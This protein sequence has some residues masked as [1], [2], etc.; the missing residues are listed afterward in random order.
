M[1]IA[2]LSADATAAGIRVLVADDDKGARTL[3]ATLLRAA[4]GVTSVIE[5]KDG[6]EAVELG[7][8]QRLDVAVL[9]FKMPR[10]DG[11]ETAITLR[12]LQPSL[13]IAV[14]SS[15]PELLR[16][17]ADGLD[18]P[19]FDKA[20]FDGLREWVE[21]QASHARAFGRVGVVSIPPKV[22]LCCSGCGYGIVSR[23]PPTRCPMCGG[24]AS[25]TEPRG[26]SSRRVALPERLAG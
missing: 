11:I 24:D 13:Q 14:H 3:L 5:A 2:D 12:A 7:S 18:L 21:R 9:H 22:D 20:D 1:P 17:R 19:W 15:D 26:W 4:A 10:L 8:E 16:T 6:V 23:K 25:W